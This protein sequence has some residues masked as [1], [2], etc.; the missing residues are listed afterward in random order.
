MNFLIAITLNG[1]A[2]W[3]SPFYGGRVSDIH[4]VRDSGSLGILEPFDPVVADRG[5]K[6]KTELAMKQC[7]LAIP[8]SATEEAQMLSNDVK[9][10]S[11]I[12]NVRIYVEQAIGRL[13]DFRILKLQQPLLHLPIIL[14]VCAALTNLKRPLTS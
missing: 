6:I 9:E 14:Y 3:L 1:A 10:T 7:N 8:P 13:K 11:N 4:I 5:F 2:S 12:A